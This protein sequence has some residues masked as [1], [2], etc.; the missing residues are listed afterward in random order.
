MDEPQHRHSIRQHGRRARCS[1]SSVA[2][3]PLTTLKPG[4]FSRRA[5]RFGTSLTF[6]KLAVYSVMKQRSMKLKLPL[7]AS[8]AYLVSALSAYAV[9]VFSDTNGAPG[10]TNS[11][12][13]SERK[14]N[15]ISPQ[16]RSSE[17]IIE[18]GN[19]V[20]MTPE[21]PAP[22]PAKLLPIPQ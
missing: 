17:I 11:T 14:T 16:L 9:S 20:V 18:Q 13:G 1:R 15:P 2:Q 8:A 3:L 4:V 5:S 12:L 22:P 10:G 6:E 21:I 19:A 7:I